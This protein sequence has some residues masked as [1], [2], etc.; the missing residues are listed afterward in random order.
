[1]QRGVYSRSVEH[2]G[3][4]IEIGLRSTAGHWQSFTLA[5]RYISI[6]ESGFG[7]ERAVHN[8]KSKG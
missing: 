4:G 3:S 5:Q 2:R 8:V 1:M 7:L 6:R